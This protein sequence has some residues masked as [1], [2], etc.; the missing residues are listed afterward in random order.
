MTKIEITDSH[1]HL[2]FNDF[3]DD[4]DEIINRALEAGVTKMITICT[5]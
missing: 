1:C 2:D 3:Q 4:L 5:K